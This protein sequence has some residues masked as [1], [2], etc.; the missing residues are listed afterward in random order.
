[1]SRLLTSKESIILASGSP[2]RRAYLKDLGL[3]F[4]V[5]VA[6]IEEK[7]LSD[8]KPDTYIERLAYAKAGNIAESNPNEWIVAADTVVCFN[9]MVLEK[10]I[11]KEDAVLMLL[12][13]SGQEHV[14]K[15]SVCLFNKERSVADICSVS[16]RVLFWKFPEDVARAYVQTGEPLDKAGSY[17]IQGKGSFLVREIHGSYSNVV[18]LPLCEFIEMLRHRQL[19]FS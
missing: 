12:R 8:E 4:S 11:D 15:T 13:L 14:V 6:D 7:I 3:S 5:S 9:N 17:G 1:M 19:I 18:G 10:P 16:T 2:R